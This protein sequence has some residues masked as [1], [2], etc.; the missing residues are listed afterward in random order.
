MLKMHNHLGFNT[1]GSF[2]FSNQTYITR[3]SGLPKSTFRGGRRGGDL[4][5]KTTE[6][7]TSENGQNLELP[8]ATTRGIAEDFYVRFNK[9]HS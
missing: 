1:L 4:K 3:S 7:E 5:R 2:V 8:L 9:I 6:N